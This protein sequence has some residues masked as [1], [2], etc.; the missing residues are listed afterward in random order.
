MLRIAGTL[1]Y[2]ALVALHSTIDARPSS[3]A[4]C[5][6]CSASMRSVASLQGLRASASERKHR[7]HREDDPTLSGER[8]VNERDA[9]T[10]EAGQH[11]GSALLRQRIRDALR[12]RGCGVPDQSAQRAS[13][14]EERAVRGADIGVG[15]E[16]R[17][18]IG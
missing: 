18:R 8:L 2:S 9:R 11:R 4:S 7:H 15:I 3:E 6:C 1:G 13:V 10:D 17:Q 16:L 12:D 14:I 5:P